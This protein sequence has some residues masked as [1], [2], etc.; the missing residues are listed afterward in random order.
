VTGLFYHALEIPLSSNN[1]H[2]RWFYDKLNKCGM[3]INGS[4]WMCWEACALGSAFD[5]TLKKMT[6]KNV[7]KA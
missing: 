1:T 3:L 6:E 4:R 2:V 7:K 5:S